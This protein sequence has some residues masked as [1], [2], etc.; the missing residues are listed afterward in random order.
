[1]MMMMIM[2]TIINYG[3]KHEDNYHTDMDQDDDDDNHNAV[4]GIG[5]EL[6]QRQLIYL[7]A[8]SRG[9]IEN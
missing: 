1:M 4:R 8:F 3:D 7:P 2:R 6:I 5:G 9:R